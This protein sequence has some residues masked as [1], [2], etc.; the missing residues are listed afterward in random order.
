MVDGLL[1]DCGEGNE[2]RWVG[3]VEDVVVGQ[4]RVPGETGIP[5]AALR[6][7]DPERGPTAG[8]PIP[9]MGDQGVRPLPHDIPTQADPGPTGQLQAD[10]RGVG[11]GTL[12]TGRIEDEQ[13]ALGT[14]SEGGQATTP[15]GHPGHRVG[16]SS[17]TAGQIEDEQIDRVARQQTARDGQPFVDGGRGDDH[18]PFEADPAADRL[19]RI[20]ATAHVEPR[21]DG[22]R[23]L[24]LRGDAEG[25]GRPPARAI[26]ADGHARGARQPAPTEDR[27]ERRE[28]GPDDPLVRIRDGRW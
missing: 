12:Q 9:V 25:E 3:W 23:R 28:A 11:D 16:P 22:T 24:G 14:S 8:R 17:P 20:E 13:Q 15:V 7:Q 6:V 18:E 2:D 5:V 21:D 19:H 10:A 4:Q 1:R 26:T 27:I